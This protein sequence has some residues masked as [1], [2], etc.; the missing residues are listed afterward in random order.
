MDADYAAADVPLMEMCPRLATLSFANR[1]NPANWILPYLPPS[2]RT[3]SIVEQDFVGSFAWAVDERAL[4]CASTLTSVSFTEEA[5]DFEHDP[6]LIRPSH[7]WG[8]LHGFVAKLV[9]VQHLRI[10][11]IALD[12]LETLATLQKLE[13]LE[14]I[15]GQHDPDPPVDAAEFMSLLERSTSLRRVAVDVI[16]GA[17]WSMTERNQVHD[18]ARQAKTEPVWL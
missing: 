4:C 17:R 3:L 2:M 13:T 10:T 5:Y 7:P 12:R 6:F 15:V 9:N 8:L 18:T 16:I 11:P 14:L 1:G